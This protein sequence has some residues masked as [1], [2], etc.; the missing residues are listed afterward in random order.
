[1]SRTSLSI[2]GII[3]PLTTPFDDRGEV[4]LAALAGNLERYRQTGLGGYLVLGSNGEA[5][6]L[7]P[8]ERAHVIA[9][10][11]QALGP[12]TQL[13]AG[14]NELSTRAA[15]VATRQAADAGADAVL[16]ATPYFYKGAMSQDALR[17]FFAEVAAAS[18]LPVLIYNVPQNTGVVIEPATIAALAAEETIVG[19]KDSS[20]NLGNLGETIRLTPDSFRVVVGSAGILY[21]SL[22]MGAC[23]AIVAAACVAPAACV[24]LYQAAT[25]GDHDRAREL[26]QRIAPL[27]KLVTTGL[28]VAG[29][30]AAL[31]LAGFAGGEPRRPLQPVS[32][33]DRERII[34]V[35][36]QSGLFP[37]LPG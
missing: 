5:V 2:S 6:H 24:E 25:R 19:V 37:N 3:P 11:R 27:G 21:P 7:T 10:T 32:G 35:M 9:A 18:P 36:R 15:I 14:V 29:L 31:E 16:V 13:I 1:M 20:G 4:D 12:G 33:S 34:T 17:D 23:G 22:L 30:K 26:Q 28:G 8:A